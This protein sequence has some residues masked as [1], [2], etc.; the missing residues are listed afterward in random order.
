MDTS[1]KIKY[2]LYRRKSTDENDRQ[3]LSLESQEKEVARHFGEK[4]QIIKLPEESVSAFEPYK[5]PVFADMLE[6]IRK[7]EAQGI[8]A[9]H[10]D[11]LSRNVLEGAQIIYLIDQGIIKDLKF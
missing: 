3:I 4:L 9:Y 5:R 7:G 8:V 10:P 6:R 2:F 1:T 11:R